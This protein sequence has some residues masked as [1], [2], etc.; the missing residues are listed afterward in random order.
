MG[1]NI[2]IFIVRLG[3]SDDG[4]FRVVQI[5]LNFLP[6]NDRNSLNWQLV[7]HA[8]AFSAT[9]ICTAYDSLGPSGLAHALNEPSC[10]SMFVNTHLLPILLQIIQDIPSLELVIYDGEPSEETLNEL[11]QKGRE[12]LRVVSLDEVEAMGRREREKGGEVWMGEKAEGD[13]TY[14]VMYTSGS[15]K[16]MLADGPS[17]VES[18]LM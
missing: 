8:C 7:A 15:S 12:G 13:D 11:K 3:E 18:K 14:C 6:R 2:S 5:K 9:P 4:S 1:R 10:R 16:S 17:Q